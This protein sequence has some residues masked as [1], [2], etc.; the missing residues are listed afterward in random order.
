MSRE[1][2]P[3]R[4]KFATI[5]GGAIL[6]GCG[7]NVSTSKSAVLRQSD[8]FKL[9]SDTTYSHRGWIGIRVEKLPKGVAGAMVTGTVPRSPAATAGIRAGDRLTHAE[10]RP[11]NN[12]EDLVR[13]IRGLEPGM[14]LI[15]EGSRGPDRKQ[16]SL[17]IE[18]SPDENE[19]LERTFVG[20]TAP[21]L[22]G[23][24]SISG[25]APPSW[26]SLRGR[27][28]VLDFWAPWCGVCHLVTSEL[29]RWQSRFGERMAV[30]GIAAGSVAQVALYAPRFHMLYAVVA[31]PEERVA[32]AF[33]AFAVP[34]V[35]VVDMEGVVR[36]IS[37]GYSPQRLTKMEKL[38]EKL[39]TPS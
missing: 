6:L 28:V 35:L 21:A 34:L 32:R 29:N 25:Q 18:P 10:G 20:Q 37:L 9:T 13:L 33:D 19:L 24:A 16:F 31:D 27:I 38:V 26:S 17:T 22:V 15:L 7:G 23:L 11:L 4:L 30:I 5:L 3:Y 39:L 12:P 1:F 36:A 2:Q 8:D 14:R